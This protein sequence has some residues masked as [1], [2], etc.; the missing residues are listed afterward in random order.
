MTQEFLLP[1]AKEGT[2][3]RRIVILN[4]T[5]APVKTFKIKP[6]TTCMT[7][8][9]KEGFT[10]MLTDLP[11][12]KPLVNFVIPRGMP[13]RFDLVQKCEIVAVTTDI[14]PTPPTGVQHVQDPVSLVQTV[15]V[16]VVKAKEMT[17]QEKLA[18]GL[19]PTNVD[20]KVVWA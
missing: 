13:R 19:K 4:E 9:A 18:A 2:I 20:G 10:F 6:S 14:L 16:E 12:E 5:G 11:D 3:E 1:P 15:G 8:P 17:I 7:V